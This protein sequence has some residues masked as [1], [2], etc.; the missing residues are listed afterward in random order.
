M[1]KT[2]IFMNQQY[3]ELMAEREQNLNKKTN[4]FYIQNNGGSALHNWR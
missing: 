4:G 2:L 3:P 1:S